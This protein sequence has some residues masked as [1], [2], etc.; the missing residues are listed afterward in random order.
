MLKS[1]YVFGVLTLISSP[2]FYF[3]YLLSY[4]F[5]HG[6][7]KEEDVNC[8]KRIGKEDLNFNGK[9]IINNV[10]HFMLFMLLAGW[11]V[12]ITLCLIISGL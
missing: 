4:S 1:S 11:L 12:M 2:L 3:F 5:R 10:M 9:I 8:K 7:R 6:W